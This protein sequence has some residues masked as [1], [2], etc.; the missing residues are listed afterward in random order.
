MIPTPTPEEMLVRGW[1]VFPARADKRPA[2]V[3]WKEFQRTRPSVAQV[4][5]WRRK[6]RPKAW[7]VVTGKISG[8]IVAD[9]DGDSGN[10]A[11][12]KLGFAPHVRTG[13]G[14]H[15][16]YVAYPG[17][18]V[19][20]INGKTKEKLAWLYPGLD[21][22]G[23]GGYAI[24]AGANEAG[25]YEWLRQPNP[26]P[27]E[28]L[29]A[30]LQELL[31]Q[32]G[33]PA[34]AKPAKP[35]TNGRV[36]AER[37]I[38]DA[39]E[40][41]AGG[42]NDAGFWL[43]T[44][45]RDN[46]YSHQEAKRIILDY[47]ARV[48]NVNAK[49]QA[50]P[51]SKDEAL[52]SVNQAYSHPAREP[53]R[54]RTDSPS[55]RKEKQSPENISVSSPPD[56]LGEFRND[57]GN[58]KR[59]IA[60]HGQSLLYC[61]AMK[62]WLVWDGR[63]WQIDGTGRAYKLAK[64]VIIE[65]LRQ[66]S[67]RSERDSEQ[68]ARHSLDHRRITA[69]LASTECEVPITPTELDAD[70]YLLNCLNGTLDL[71]TFELRPHQP[72]DHI[73]K[74]VHLRYDPT[75]RCELFLQSLHRIMGKGP[76]ATNAE[77]ERAERLAAYLQ[78]A[79]GYC[80]TGDV[81]EKVIFCLFGSGNNGKTTLLE[82]IRYVV[83]EYA[84][85]VQID[86]L[87][88]HRQRES[89]ASL[90]DLADLRGARFVT[91]SEV[92]QGS[93]L[94]EGKLKYL[95][96]GTSEIKTCRK[97][98]NP[99]AFPATHKL[100]I[101]ANHK[102]IVRGTDKAIWNR[103]KLIPFVVSVPESEI[104]KALLDK[105]KAEAEGI[106]AWMVEGCRRWRAEGLGDPPEVAEASAEWRAEMSLLREFV[107][108]RCELRPEGFC[109]VAEIQRAY[110]SW[111]KENGRNDA[112]WCR[113]FNDEMTAMGCRYERRRVNGKQARGWKGIALQSLAEESAEV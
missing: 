81:S 103:L 56:L 55:P 47:A 97:Y 90:A 111:A 36:P 92:E 63:R 52:A 72:A 35:K 75:A 10:A 71:R 64:E 33:E 53:W 91:T 108:D 24:F 45:L 16:L 9:F 44:Q 87:L 39:L 69:M 102:P 29:P 32:S 62:R 60:V 98:E 14:G 4:H 70:P 59:L 30:D 28:G 105:F 93:H 99:I 68:F 42:R 94:A 50:D 85:Q 78:K 7:A 74:V 80:L 86:T 77:G 18:R 104:D 101:D 66:T 11:L 8:L 67:E 41:A 46:R 43:A 17:F 31:K 38:S 96:A 54:S 27:F 34:S 107:E 51:Y 58:A 19:P 100:F 112:T 84:A 12:G 88:S 109:S 40:R 76:D 65:F 13:S 22:R 23:D 48:P 79:F 37:L 89:N 82:A 21:I 3:S 49:G 83:R 61:H 25:M 57:H 113:A 106:L 15:H 5:E 20:T 95:T 6:L 73:T 110:E 1:S 26:D 2:I